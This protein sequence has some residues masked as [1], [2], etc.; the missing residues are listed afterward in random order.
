[1]QDA[2]VHKHALEPESCGN[3]E[4]LEEIDGVARGATSSF[5]SPPHEGNKGERERYKSGSNHTSFDYVKHDKFPY[6][7]WKIIACSFCGLDNHNVSRCWKKM[8]T[9]M[10]LLK[11][12]KQEAKGQLDKANHVVKRMHMCCT[13]YHKQGHI[14]EKCWTLNPTMFP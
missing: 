2:D 3:S 8:A 9:Y 13:Y 4:S 12:R 1:L 11:E 6:K 14:A 5:N 10:K 7:H